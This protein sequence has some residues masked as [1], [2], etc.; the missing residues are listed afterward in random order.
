[1]YVCIYVSSLYENTEYR[2]REGKGV[3]S[4]ERNNYNIRSKRKRF[5]RV[6]VRAYLF[7]MYIEGLSCV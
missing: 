1:M 7:V 2:G 4:F 5:R 6:R 3:K